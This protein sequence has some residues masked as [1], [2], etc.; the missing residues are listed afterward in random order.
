MTITEETRQNE[1]I[2]PE[3]KSAF[4]PVRQRLHQYVSVYNSK[5]TFTPVS[6]RS[7]QYVNFYNSTSTFTPVSQRRLHQYVIVYTSKQDAKCS[8]SWA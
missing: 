5:S 6:E 1:A 7:H 2:A 8:R 3:L 4:T